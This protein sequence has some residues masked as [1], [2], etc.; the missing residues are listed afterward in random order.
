MKRYLGAVF[1]LFFA[2][3]IA[4]ACSEQGASQEQAAV[5]REAQSQADSKQQAAAMPGG[6]QPA[7]E[8]PSEQAATSDEEIKG[9]VVKTDE[10]IVIFSDRGSYMVAGQDLEGLV[11][12][13]VKITGMVEE[14]DGRSVVTISSV[15]VIE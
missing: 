6:Q 12:K 14:T 2:L 11:G 3:T 7:A 1:V 5:K 8:M 4:M 13:N 15:A 9:T 10:G